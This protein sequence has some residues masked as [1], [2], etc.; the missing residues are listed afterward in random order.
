MYLY[1]IDTEL[2]VNMGKK[3]NSEKRA[4]FIMVIF[5]ILLVLYSQFVAFTHM[6]GIISII[7]F[8]CG[9]ILLAI[10]LPGLLLPEK[11]L[12]KFVSNKRAGYYVVLLVVVLLAVNLYVRLVINI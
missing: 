9:P 5:G 10:G 4:S 2:V 3:N 11:R 12:N 7:S 6:I 1:S 8:I